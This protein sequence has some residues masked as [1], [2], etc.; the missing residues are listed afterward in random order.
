MRSV[1]AAFIAHRRSNMKV[2]VDG[3]VEAL[4]G[5]QVSGDYFSG[6]GIS[7][8]IGR[9]ITPEDER[10][11]TPTRVAVLSDSYWA[12]RFARDPGVLGRTIRVDDVPHLVVGVTR[13]EFFGIEVGR[14][15]DVTVPIDG[16][17]YRQGW[18]SMALVVRLP[19]NVSPS[20][21]AGELTALIRGFSEACGRQTSRQI[22]LAA[23]GVGAARQWVGNARHC[24]RTVYEAGRDRVGHDRNAAAARLHELGDAS[25]SAEHLLD[26]V[27]WRF[28]SHS[29]P[30]DSRWP[31]RQ[32]S[33][34]R[35]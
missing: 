11:A 3:Q 17:E 4:S 6:L 16:S 24:P 25:V 35:R 19:P 26:S 20:A 28:A 7:P 1:S 27:K 31:A 32:L 5:L 9:L 8:Q 18:A 23:S 10:G 14:R 2:I 13:R 34:A 29:D 30:L 21:A 22:A 33:R 15:V 12:R